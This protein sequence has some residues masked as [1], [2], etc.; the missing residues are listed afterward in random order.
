MTASV[1][2]TAVVRS[3][4]AEIEMTAAIAPS[5]ERIGAT[6]PIFPILSAE[7][8]KRRPVA[9]PIPDTASQPAA[10]RSS[11]SGT[12]AAATHGVMTTSP[13]SITPARNDGGATS[14]EPRDDDSVVTA[15]STAV[16]RP[17]ATAIMRVP[18]HA[19][20]GSCSPAGTSGSGSP[21]RS[22]NAS[23]G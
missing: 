12:P 10:R 11:V 23:T 19:A 16:P 13:T 17:P 7:Y 2:P 3:S 9:F 22:V 1:A 18:S 14:R 8:A 6:S 21:R 5:V 4:P 15:N 20:A